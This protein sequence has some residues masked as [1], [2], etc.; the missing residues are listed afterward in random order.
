MSRSEG[1][2]GEGEGYEVVIRA[3]YRG[4]SK[5]RGGAGSGEHKVQYI[6][7]LVGGRGKAE[8]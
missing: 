8:G 2:E 4:N 5:V 6:P 3:F 7:C 1:R